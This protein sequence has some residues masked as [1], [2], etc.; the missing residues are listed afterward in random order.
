MFLSVTTYCAKGVW[1]AQRKGVCLGRCSREGLF[2]P[3][4]ERWVDI[5]QTC[6][7][8]GNSVETSGHLQRWGGGGRARRCHW[9]DCSLNL[10]VGFLHIG[11]TRLTCWKCRFWGQSLHLASDKILW[12]W[13]QVYLIVKFDNLRTLFRENWGILQNVG[14]GC[15]QSRF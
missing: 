3:I 2:E 4:L 1:E 14:Q 5:N 7:K 12:R 15:G 6:L 8:K 13:G 10:T 11:I 9:K